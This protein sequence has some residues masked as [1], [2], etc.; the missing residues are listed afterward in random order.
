ML[1]SDIVLEITGTADFKAVIRLYA[2][3]TIIFLKVNTARTACRRLHHPGPNALISDNANTCSVHKALTESAG[4]SGQYAA[5][6]TPKGLC[7]LV[8]LNSPASMELNE[9]GTTDFLGM[10]LVRSRDSQKQKGKAQNEKI[11]ER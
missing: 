11:I 10:P 2:A 1:L 7:R 5:T 4:N 6:R 3:S 8:T 9:V